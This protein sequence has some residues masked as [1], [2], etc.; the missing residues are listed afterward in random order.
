MDEAIKIMDAPGKMKH[1]VGP[2]RIVQLWL[3]AILA[4]HVTIEW[5]ILDDIKLKVE[6]ARLIYL[7][8]CRNC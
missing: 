6:G 1:I 3:N 4:N 8:P 5:G 7:T 2:L